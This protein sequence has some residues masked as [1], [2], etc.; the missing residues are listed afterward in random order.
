MSGNLLAELERSGHLREVTELDHGT[1]GF[2]RSMVTDPEGLPELAETYRRHRYYLEMLTCL[3]RRQV[4]DSMRLVYTFNRLG[5]SD[6]HLVHVDL[7]AVRP[8]AGPPAKGK[9]RP[10]PGEGEEA[11]PER[12]ALP[13]TAP[14]LAAIFPAADWYER[15]VF[16]MYGVSFTG[17]PDLKRILLPPDTNFHALLKDFGRMEDAPPGDAHD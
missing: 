7:A 3:D 17:H 9:A 2:Q 15:E 4:H 8:W 1:T 16:D 6:R 10:A 14:S 13:E 12:P 5:P 11:T